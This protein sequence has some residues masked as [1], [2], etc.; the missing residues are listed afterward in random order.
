MGK[1][2]KQCTECMKVQYSENSFD[3]CQKCG[4]K[5]LEAVS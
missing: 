2:L 4:M 1:E 3:L 5:R